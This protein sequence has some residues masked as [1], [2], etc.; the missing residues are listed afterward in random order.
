MELVRLDLSDTG[1]ATQLLTLQRRAYEV[2]AGLVGS[3]DIPPLRETLKELQSCGETFLGALVEGRVV[4]AISWRLLGETLDLHRLVV[5]PPHF[6]RR[7]GVTL[8]RAAL[9][10]EPSASRAIVQTGADNEP[11]KTLYLR[12]GFEQTD[13]VE[14]V[15][16]LRV[17]RFSKRLRGSCSQRTVADAGA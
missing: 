11:S 7:I 12:E 9:A 13:E 1:I 4:G 16:G 6:R 17:A 2:E 5:D 3:N 10:A 14:I 8:V 15:P